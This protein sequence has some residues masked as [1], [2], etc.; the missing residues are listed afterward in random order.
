MMLK[1]FDYYIYFYIFI[2][3]NGPIK[4]YLNKAYIF[5]QQLH[6]EG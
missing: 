1:C 2:S 4:A 5:N 6:C 3:F